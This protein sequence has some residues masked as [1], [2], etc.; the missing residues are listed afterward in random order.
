MSRDHACEQTLHALAAGRAFVFTVTNYDARYSLRV[1]PLP[2]RRLAPPQAPAPTR[3][4]T[5]LPARAGP[6]P[7]LRLTPNHEV[8]AAERAAIAGTWLDYFNR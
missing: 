8:D 3:V 7:V 1:Y 5:P 2:T 4:P 6:A